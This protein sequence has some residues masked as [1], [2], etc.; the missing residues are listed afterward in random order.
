MLLFGG[1]GMVAGLWLDARAGGFARL[2][3]LCSSN[4]DPSDLA[5]LLAWHWS[6][7]PLAHLGMVAGGLAGVATMPGLRAGWRRWCARL[8][9]NLLCSGGMLLG[10][11]A[12]WLALLQLAAWTGSGAP[13][14][15]MLAAMF[16]G[17][18]WGMAASATV[19]HAAAGLRAGRA[20]AGSSNG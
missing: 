7:L 20:L 8:L 1:V 17:M 6:E 5:R 3:A 4:P 18:A 12:G 13:P 15:A 2:A 9:R 14:A 16:A 19:V 11:G 10:M